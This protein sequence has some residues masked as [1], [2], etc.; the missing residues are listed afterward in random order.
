MKYVCLV[1]GEE[2]DLYALTAE[3]SAKLD[4]DSLAYDRSLDQQGKLIVAQALQSV[5]TAKTVRRRTGKRL[6]IDG[7]FAE[8]KEQLLGFVMVEAENL[9]EALDIAAGI[10]LA[11]I[12]TIE[13]RAV[14]D[15]PGS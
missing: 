4:A 13:V 1:Y 3:R 7:P 5:T 11:E 14:Y 2:K 9:D 15:I 6:I 10:P 8:T 12:G